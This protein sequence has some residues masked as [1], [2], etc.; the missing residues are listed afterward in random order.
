MGNTNRTAGHN[1]EREVAKDFVQ[2]G[3]QNCKTS[4]YASREKDDQK[5]DLCYTEPFNIQCKRTNQ[6]PNFQE[7][8]SSMPQS[9]GYNIVIHRRPKRKG[10]KGAGDVA[11]MDKRTFYAMLYTLK[12]SDLLQ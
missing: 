2:M 11:V 8:L 1:L 12:R 10:T 9:N 5:V 7:L 6:A 3:F 4:R